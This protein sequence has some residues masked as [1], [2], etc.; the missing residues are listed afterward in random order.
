MCGIKDIRGTGGQNRA[1]GELSL[2]GDWSTR[3]TCGEMIDV[4]R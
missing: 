2:P 4:P 3:M 1:T